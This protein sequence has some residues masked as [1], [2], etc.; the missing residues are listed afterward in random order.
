MFD[1]VKSLF[2]NITLGSSF[3]ITSIFNIPLSLF[4][5]QKHPLAPFSVFR[6]P[7]SVLRAPL[8]QK[9]I[10]PRSALPGSHTH[11]YH[12]VFSLEVSFAHF[13]EELDGE[14]G[15]GTAEWVTQGD[16]TSVYVYAFAV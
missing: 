11:R 1:I 10:H 6:S 15:A 5:L 13:V 3:A 14:F 9:L 12:S 8:S 7:C 2:S 4:S 16:G